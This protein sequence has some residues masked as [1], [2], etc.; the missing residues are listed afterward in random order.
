MKE[1]PSF[2]EL[3]ERLGTGD[4]SVSI[5]AKRASEAGKSVWET[6][7][8][9]SNEPDAAGGYF[10]FGVAVK[11]GSLFPDYEVVGVDDLDKL[12]RDIATQCRENFSSIIRPDMV[13][14]IFNEKRVLVVYIPEAL[15]HEKPVYISTKGPTKGAYRRIG[16][17]DQ[18]CADHDLAEFYQSR[19]RESFDENTVDGTT[20]DDI[21]TMALAAYR[22][23]RANTNDAATLELLRY[24]DAE[25]LHALHA[26]TS[27][28][29]KTQLTIAG[30]AL[31]GKVACLRRHMPMTRIDYIRV[32]GREWISDIENRYQSIEKLG[33]LLVT[34]P[35]LISQILDDIPKAF[36]LQGSSIY[37]KDLPLIPGKVI[38][39]AV[40]N[41][42]MHRNYRS[43]EPVQIIRYAN[44]LEIKNPGYSLVPEEKLGEPGSRTRNPKIAAAL[45]DAGL[46]ETK[47]TGI[48]VMRDAME[49]ANLTSPIIAS[50]RARDQF[51]L[52]LLVHHLLGQEDIKWLA[53]FRDCNLLDD[54]ARALVIVREKGT[55]DNA[56]YRSLNRVDALT[57]SNRLRSLRD[58]GLLE[59]FGAGAGTHY[60]G[61]HRLTQKSRVKGKGKKVLR[62]EL[63]EPL[64][65]EFDLLRRE[66][67]EHLSQQLDAL[68]QRNSPEVL[69]DLI[70]ELCNWKAMSLAQIAFLVKRDG[71]HLQNGCIKRLLLKKRL[72]LF[73]PEQP[74]HPQ[75]KY[76]AGEFVD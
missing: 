38:R 47:G 28:N 64:R 6:I 30:L 55:I 59:Q 34:I 75:Q 53:G 51:S 14:S 71:V 36:A 42:L 57:A 26:T 20:I 76:V 32:D 49:T 33:P 19:G 29:G 12:Q 70:Q 63:P 44:R 10:L 24:P 67:P 39:E 9:F 40:V 72:L 46:A 8:A 48:R 65:R 2:T 69:D 1:L 61:G 17:T 41:A 21:D 50:D 22:T 15:P 66:L 62:R 60:A 56:T 74:N 13:A 3:W 73:H 45:H 43:H 54:D 25:L 5:E 11:D 35:Q 68:K 7:S 31:F 16:S 37:R 18:I 4:E 52:A 23:A 58:Q 27:E